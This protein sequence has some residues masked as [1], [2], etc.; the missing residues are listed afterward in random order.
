MAEKKSYLKGLRIL[1]VDD[2]EDVLDTIAEALEMA[3]VDRAQDFKTAVKKISQNQY[4]LA[5]LDIMG[6]DGLT[7][8]DKTV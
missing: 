2:E 4:D 5:I 1:A 6:V 3:A 7:L 8:L